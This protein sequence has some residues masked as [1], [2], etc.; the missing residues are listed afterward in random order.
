MKPDSTPMV[1]EPKLERTIEFLESIG[2]RVTLGAIEGSTVFPGIQIVRGTL[3]VDPT[4]LVAI[5]D[6]VH[7]AAHVALAPP[8][9]RSLDGDFLTNA[10]GGEEVATI[11]WSWAALQLLGLAP[12]EVFH[13]TAYPRGDSGS[14]IT[15]GAGGTFI[16]F[17]LLQYWGMAFDEEH[18]NALGVQPYPHMV[19]WLRV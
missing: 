11:A 10:D 16:G 5:G 2:I 19:R 12:E 17:P 7:E 3:L 9:R 13:G 18:A 15:A 8:E 14:I 6:V 4:K 1:G